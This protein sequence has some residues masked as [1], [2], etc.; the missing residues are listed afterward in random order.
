M[1]KCVRIMEF[2]PTGGTKKAAGYLAEGIRKGFLAA[3]IPVEEGETVD[4]LDR[5]FKGVAF[6]PEEL[7]VAA[8]PAFGGRI[9]ALMAERLE[10]VRA[11][12]AGGVAV[13]VYG[14]RAYEDCFAELG[15][16]LED[17]GFRLEAA[18]ALLAE[19][20]MVR[21]VAAGRPDDRDREEILGFGEKIAA[22]L[23]ES[24]EGRELTLPGNRPYKVWNQMPFA[25]VPDESC[26]ACGRCGELCP[27]GAI[28]PEDPGK[29][30]L[31]KCILC[32]RCAAV[33]P[34]G[35]RK[36]PAPAAALLAEKLFP[37][38]DLRRENELFLPE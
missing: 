32:M 11:E 8:A 10:L 19:H 9:P 27:T 29:V 7:V 28:A 30:E 3:G 23:M 26:T 34:L 13:I 36:L 15:D 5:E 1:Y 24:S 33:C 31:S 2:S 20:S 37:I 21:E 25:P 22:S 35:A 38:R 17:C 12:G 14:N 4:L 16:C 6:G 18:A